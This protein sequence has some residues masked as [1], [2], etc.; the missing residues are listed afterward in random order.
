MTYDPAQFAAGEQMISANG[1]EIA[2]QTF[3]D[4]SA[5]PMLFVMG[6]GTQMIGWPEDLL[7]DIADRGYYVIRYD[8]RDIGRST[9]LDHL[10][11]MSFAQ[12]RSFVT[13]RKRPPYEIADMADDALGLLDALGIETAHL[14]GV[15]MGG[16]ISQTAVLKA[17]KRFHSLTLIMTSTGSKRV[18]R[19]AP[20]LVWRM[21]QQKPPSSIEEAIEGTLATYQVIGSPGFEFDAEYLRAKC[22]ASFDRDPRDG[23][24]YLRQ[25]AASVAQPNRTDGLRRLTLPTLVMHGLADRLVH[26]SG[27]MAIAKAIPGAK[28]VGYAGMGHD[29]PRPLW[30]DMADQISALA[31]KADAQRRDRTTVTV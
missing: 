10:P 11:S 29:L 22:I 14:V 7:Q 6:L 17:P 18:G 30:P 13:G 19:P 28:F 9:H 25:L 16:F 2:Y 23:D 12:L 26:P 24:G 21:S 15:S 31:Q 20:A 1:I 3:G 27:G 8:N 5:T 4:P